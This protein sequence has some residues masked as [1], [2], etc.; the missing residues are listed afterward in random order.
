MAVTYYLYCEETG[1]GVAV[2]QDSMGVPSDQCEPS[3][4]VSLFCLAHRDRLLQVLADPDMVGNWE[5]DD[6]AELFHEITGEQAPDAWKNLA[7]E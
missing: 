6:A 4:V 3:S 1:H 7:N 2:G 5:A